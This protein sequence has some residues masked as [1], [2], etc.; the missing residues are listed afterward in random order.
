MERRDGLLLN[1]RDYLGREVDREPFQY[2]SEAS[3]KEIGVSVGTATNTGAL[4]I[5]DVLFLHDIAAK[6]LSAF[7]TPQESLEGYTLVFLLY[8]IAVCGLCKYAVY[9]QKKLLAHNA[10]VMPLDYVPSSM[11]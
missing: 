2:F 3:V 1:Q 10:L 8:R 11:L 9:L 7:S 4:V 5:M 6:Q